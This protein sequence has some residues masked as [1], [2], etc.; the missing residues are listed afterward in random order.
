MARRPKSYRPP[1]QPSRSEQNRAYETRRG[2]AVERGYGHRWAVSSATHRRHH[3]LCAYCALEGRVTACQLTDHLYPHKGDTVLFWMT[4]Y[5][6]S[7]CTPCHSGFKQ[8]IEHQGAEA[9]DALA[10]RLGLP[11]LPRGGGSTPT[12]PFT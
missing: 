8:Q 10:R 2:S 5:W 3:P 12:H 7:S 1:H 4:E 11:P 6:V 9:L